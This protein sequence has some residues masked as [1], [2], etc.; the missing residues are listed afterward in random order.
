MQLP[1]KHE[2]LILLEKRQTESIDFTAH[3]TRAYRAKKPRYPLAELVVE[4]E[5]TVLA[6]GGSPTEVLSGVA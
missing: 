3:G 6:D 4:K 2:P 5:R 1:R